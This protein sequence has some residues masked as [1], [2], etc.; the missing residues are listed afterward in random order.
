MDLEHK[1][2][3]KPR[4]VAQANIA[5]SKGDWQLEV[6]TEQRV[7]RQSLGITALIEN[8]VTSGIAWNFPPIGALKALHLVVN[9]E[10]NVELSDSGEFLAGKASLELEG[11]QITPPWDP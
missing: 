1:N 3:E 11:G 8:L 7:R 4:L 9:G 5:S 2:S 6:R 10:T